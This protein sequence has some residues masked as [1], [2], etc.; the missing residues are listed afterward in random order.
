MGRTSGGRIGLANAA[1][2]L[3]GFQTFA[4]T[5]GATTVITVP[6]GRTW[7]GWVSLSVTVANA[8]ANAVAAAA[9]G[10]LTTA[11]AGVTPA[12]GTYLRCD[13]FAGA[14]VAAGTVGDQD[15][16][17]V[18]MPFVVAAPAGNP[19]TLQATATIAGSAGQV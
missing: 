5:T 16:S 14:N 4:A 12:A 1:T 3:A 7:S 19:V 18:S 17:T 13:A 10:T 2:V 9:T 15:A 6:A 8:G 11:G